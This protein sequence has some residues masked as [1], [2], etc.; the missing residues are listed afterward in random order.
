MVGLKWKKLYLKLNYIKFTDDI[1]KIPELID[2]LK[3][4]NNITYDN[5]DLM[6]YYNKIIKCIAE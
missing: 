4:L 3:K 2:E 6:K 1:E 5:S